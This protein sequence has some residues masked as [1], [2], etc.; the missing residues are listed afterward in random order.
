[1]KTNRL[2]QNALFAALLAI[3]SQFSIPLGPLPLSL[4]IFG[5]F[6][7]GLMLRPSDAAYAVGIFL[8][9]GA[10][11]VPVFAGFKGGLSVL[12]GMT[13]GFLI[14]YL[15]IACLTAFSVSRS[16]HMTAY[17]RTAVVLCSELAGLAACYALGTAWFML[18]SGNPL[19]SALSACVIPFILPDCL[20]IVL[21]YGAALL[22]KRRLAKA[23]LLQ[24]A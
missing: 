4:G 12:S 2:A 9:L 15:L 24:A 6:L 11:G 18:V 1:M 8:L 10:A 13:G 14:G 22:L 17:A 7:T 16:K 19:Q 23:G 21:A 20:K 5:A 3:L